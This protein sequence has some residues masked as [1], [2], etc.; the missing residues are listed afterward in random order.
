MGTFSTLFYFLKYRKFLI[1]E[2]LKKVK[3]EV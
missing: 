1:Y 3:L 2:I